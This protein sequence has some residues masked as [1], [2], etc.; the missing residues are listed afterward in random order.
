MMRVNMG[1]ERAPTGATM[2]KLTT[3]HPGFQNVAEDIAK[4]EGISIEA[5]RAILAKKSRTA[6]T[7][8]KLA[9]PA[10]K[11]VG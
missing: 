10:L 5:A 11:K 9:N 2:A 4:R 6:S 8:A 3:K 1:A 7:K